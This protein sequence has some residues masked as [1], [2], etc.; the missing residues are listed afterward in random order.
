MLKHKKTIPNLLLVIILFIQNVRDNFYILVMCFILVFIFGENE[1]IQG[2]LY[3][4]MVTIFII[5]PLKLAKQE[6]IVQK[7]TNQILSG[8]NYFYFSISE[9]LINNFNLIVEHKNYDLNELIKNTQEFFD[10][11]KNLLN[12]T[13]EEK[14]NFA[15]NFKMYANGT[16]APKKILLELKDV[17]SIFERLLNDTSIS[18]IYFQLNEFQGSVQSVMNIHDNCSDPFSVIS[19]LLL[20]S[21]QLLIIFKELNKNYYLRVAMFYRLNNDIN[22]QKLVNW[23]LSQE[24]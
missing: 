14:N 6:K 21:E 20:S 18:T 13:D 19:S 23:A 15:N 5:E 22:P 12:M 2:A 1:F 7:Q 8:I 3:C 11:R 4:S 10:I 17:M 16:P 24:I 9:P